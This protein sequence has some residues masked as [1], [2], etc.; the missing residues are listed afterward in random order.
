MSKKVKPLSPEEVEQQTATNIPDA[1]IMAVN[2]LLKKYFRNG[3]AT[4]PQD[5]ILSEVRRIDSKL[6]ADFLCD[7]HYLDFEPLFQ[8]AGWKVSY[9]KPGWNETGEAYFKFERS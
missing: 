1:V 3:H 5:E 4:I 2:T 9:D 6:K 7:N 8:R